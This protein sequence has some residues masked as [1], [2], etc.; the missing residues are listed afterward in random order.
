VKEAFGHRSRRRAWA[1]VAGGGTGG[2]AVPAIAIA[3][4][5]VARGHPPSS[6]HFVGSRRGVE[7]RLV[8]AAGFEATLLPGRGLV[9]RPSLDNLAAA[10]GLL[11]AFARAVLLVGR[12]RPA[13]V[14]AVG[15][16]AS[17]AAAAAAV[18]WRVPLVVA[19]QN[20]VPGLANRL[21]G[22]FAA[23][24]AVSF[25]GTPL[26]RAVLTGN[27]VRSE[28]AHADTGPAGREAARRALGVPD[29]RVAV[30]AV[31]GS[32]GS[33]RINEAVLGLAARWAG[34]GDVWL[35]HVVGRRDYAEVAARR[36]PA[37]PGGL[38]YE[39][40]EFEDRM[41]LLLVASDAAVQRA[42]ASTVAE[43]AAVGIPCVLVPLPGAPGDHQ[44]ENAR[45][46]EAA[47]AAVVV[48]DEELDAERL[49]RELG[50]LVADA[51]ARRRMA[52]AARSLAR[53]RAAEDVA[54]LAERHALRGDPRRDR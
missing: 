3:E 4:A 44:T 27:P 12:L 54:E 35:R 6:I 37:E 46:L 22:R 19:E 30:A 21:A 52:S 11:A 41:D 50:R 29:G 32:L 40:V 28:I 45:R 38:C 33:R 16:W 8:A 39:Q 18:V 10:A 1:V 48:P 13:V 9:R 14:V 17:A 20:A 15:G 2:H 7:G 47:G 26:P 24:C 53:P 25:E 43:V 34:R 31:G 5:L 42:G 36:P 51:E 23:A 49:E